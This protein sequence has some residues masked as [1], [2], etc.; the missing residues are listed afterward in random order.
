M[1]KRRRYEGHKVRNNAGLR[2]GLAAS[3]AQINS[4]GGGSD[5]VGCTDMQLKVRKGSV[6]SQETTCSFKACSVYLSKTTPPSPA[7][8]TH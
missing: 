4:W 5:V 1:N 6:V 2:E 3:L 8:Q 7:T